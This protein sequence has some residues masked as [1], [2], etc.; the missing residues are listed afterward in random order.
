MA[1][2]RKNASAIPRD[3]RQL[4][5]VLLTEVGA[6]GRGN[7]QELEDDRQD[8]VEVP[9]P[10]RALQHASKLQL[11]VTRIAVAVR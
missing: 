6:L 10:V 1:V 3:E 7:L 8:A 5:P 9:G 4:L 11:S 2:G